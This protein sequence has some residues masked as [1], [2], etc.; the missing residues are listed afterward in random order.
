MPEPTMILGG[1]LTAVLLAAGVYSSFEESHGVGKAVLYS[2]LFTL[3][4]LL[5]VAVGMWRQS[6]GS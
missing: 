5:C 1:L 6:V 3:F 4:L 2:V